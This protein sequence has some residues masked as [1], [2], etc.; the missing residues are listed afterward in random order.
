MH[1]LPTLDKLLLI[2]VERSDN[3]VDVTYRVSGNHL[4]LLEK[5]I[6]TKGQSDAPA[7]RFKLVADLTKECASFSVEA[8]TLIRPSQYRCHDRVY[9]RDHSYDDRVLVSTLVIEL[10]G[11]SYAIQLKVTVLL[12][13]GFGQI[14]IEDQRTVCRSTCVVGR[15]S[16]GG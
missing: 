11:I 8:L 10:Y 14:H 9:E 12:D 16:G 2:H 7:V 3:L 15:C 4:S 1:P 5:E 6:N 13:L